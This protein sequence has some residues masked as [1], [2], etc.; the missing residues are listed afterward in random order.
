M[1]AIEDATDMVTAA[2]LAAFPWLVLCDHPRTQH[3]A[4]QCSLSPAA[5]RALETPLPRSQHCALKGHK[6]VAGSRTEHAHVPQPHS[7]MGSRLS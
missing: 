7:A 1:V 2:P 3:K 4:E 6:Y 5:P